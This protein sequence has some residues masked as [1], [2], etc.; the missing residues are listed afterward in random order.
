RGKR[1]SEVDP[2]ARLVERFAV[3][4]PIR[5]GSLIVT[6]FGDAILPRG[7]AVL[8]ADLMAL[9]RH[10][11]LNDSQVRTAL[12][13]LVADHWLAAERRGR[14]SLYRPTET[15]RHRFEEATRRIY[16]GP[17]RDWS[18]EWHVLVLPPGAERSELAKDLGWLG[19][20]RL[21]PGVMLH[22]CPD[23]ASLASVIRDAPADARPLAIAGKSDMAAPPN[24]PDL[25]A[26]C[27]D[28]AALAESYRRFLADFA[29]LRQWL[30]RGATPE[31]L[32]ALLARL[33]LIHDYRRLILRD[34][35][36][37]PAL[38]PRDWIGR[39]AYD[40]ARELYHALAPAAERWIDDN[41]SGE[42]GRLPKPDAAFRRR[43]P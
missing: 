26:R 29:A 20:G 14:Q 28:L 13:R 2:I 42:S 23:L 5:S 19:F 36:L 43:F 40:A 22:P 25:V 8:L 35:M 31:P 38:L 41:L 21:A 33:L 7:G 3:R 39:A 16:A 9:L 24:L 18:G 30:A 6:A 12:S 27:W 15:G 34:P 32:P 37:P 11:S 1:A 4:Q 17:P 10:F